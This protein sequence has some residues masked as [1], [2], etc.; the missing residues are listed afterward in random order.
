MRGVTRIAVSMFFIVRL[1][2]PLLAVAEGIPAPDDAPKPNPPEVSASL[3]RLEPGLAIELVAGDE[4]L[5]DPVDMAFDAKGRIFVCEIHGYNLEGYYDILELNKS[6]VLDT[7]VRRIDASPEAQ[8]RAEEGQYGTVKM[9]EDSDGDGRFDKAHVWA[10]RLPPCYGV[11]PA[12]DGVIVVCSPQVVFLADRD[13][14]GSAEI[15]QVL[16][17][18]DGGP[19]W[20]RPSNPRWN[21][22]NWI[23]YDGGFRFKPDGSEQQPTTGNGQFGHATTDWGDRFYIVQSQPVRYV[24]PLPYRY[25]ARNPFHAADAGIVSLLPYDDLYPISQPDPWRVKRGT[26]PAWLK[27][28][29]ELE[30]TPNGF[31][32][33]ACGNLIYR[34]DD[35]PEPYRQDNYFFCENAQNLIHRCLLRRDGAGFKVERAR[36]DKKEFLATE[37]IWFRPVNLAQ[38]PDGAIYIVDMY[39]EIIEDY[40][41]IPRFLQQQYVE[42]LIAGHDRGRIWRLKAEG[43][44]PWRP[45]DMT[46][47]ST[48]KLVERLKDSN[49]WWRDTAQRLLVERKDRRAAA[50]L[51]TLARQGE[52]PQA[53]LHAL[54]TLEGLGALKREVVAA[55]LEDPHFAVRAHAVRLSEPWLDGRESLLPKLAAMACEEPDAKVR[56]QLALSLGET[57]ESAAAGAMATLARSHG[58]DPWMADA[59]LCSAAETA[60]VLLCDLIRMGENLGEAGALVPKLAA[61]VGTRRDGG[62]LTQILLAVAEAKAPVSTRT[63]AIEGL[64]EG[65][66][67]G[68]PEPL[69][70]AEGR[71]ALCRLLTDESATIQSLAVEVA[72]RLRLERSDELQTALAAAGERAL[73]AE[74]AEEER[75]AALKLLRSAP[76]EVVVDMTGELLNPAQP[77]AVQV[78]AV[79]TLSSFGDPRVSEVLLADFIRFTPRLQQAV[80]T[81]VFARENRLAG[82]LDAIEEETLRPTA[83]DAAQRLRLS[84]NRDPALRERA[85][86]LLG[87]GATRKEREEVLQRYVTALRD[88]HD[89]KHGGKVFD[90]QCA[91]CHKLDGRGFE[92]GPDLGSITRRADETLVSDI[93]DPARE[94]TVGYQNYSVVTQDGRIFTG[95]LGAET[96]TSITLRQEEGKEETILRR[97]ID[98]M[99]ASSLSMMPEELDKLVTPSDV[100]ALIAYLRKTLGAVSP[101]TVTLFDDHPEVV[102]AL[103]EGDGSAVLDESDALSGTASLSVTPLQRHSSAI[104]GWQYRITENPAPGE[105]RYIRF[106]WKSAGAKGVMVELAAD[107]S[108]PPPEVPLRRYYSGKNTTEWA[109]V[110]VDPQAPPE[111]TVVTRDL[112]ADFGSFTL[113][114]IAPTAMGGP[115]KFD[116]IELLREVP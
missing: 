101:A 16:Y 65:L 89:V 91:K 55:A 23:Y 81:A 18:T 104:E 4:L 110:E 2:N 85:R 86:A 42:S 68:E 107:G 33:S 21:I 116:R 62:E 58:N 26:D 5:D 57:K 93:L 73:D 46:K 103:C 14:D 83:L 67:R 105:Y 80:L 56:L 6:G 51:E 114:G 77:P 79:E 61:V 50:P 31:V 11:V 87:S 63:A 54:C 7:Q 90:E 17:E 95:V 106:A 59:I 84:E 82:L 75:I 48:E 96:A 36:N 41:A 111:W 25:L 39:R 69:D 34:G 30:A 27:F 99:E 115:A 32:T 22:D 9:L 113:T 60:D 8:K 19:M 10:D 45:V 52:T 20:N 94:I 100:G 38:G 40:S 15:R 109:A 98:E 43:G 28:Y 76:F 29:G 78:A 13:G 44:R 97:D 66:D 108:W 1:S 92:V 72:G 71:E 102:N 74:L 47:E 12:G 37:E 112:W 53:R 24:V 88:A 49:A 3:F 35:L 64:L 70:S